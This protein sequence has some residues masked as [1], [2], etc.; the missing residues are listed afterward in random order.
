VKNT[1]NRRVLDS[2]RLTRQ[3]AQTARLSTLLRSRKIFIPRDLEQLPSVR[4]A[5]LSDLTV[6]AVCDR[7]TEDLEMACAD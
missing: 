1:F 2:D 3:L 6:G 5:I 7:A 4:T